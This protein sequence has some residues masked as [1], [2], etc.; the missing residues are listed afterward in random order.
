MFRTHRVAGAAMALA[1]AAAQA[2][3]ITGCAENRDHRKYRAVHRRR[4]D[5][6]VRSVEGVR[7]VE[8]D[9]VVR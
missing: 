3:A 9:L 2:P 1:L 7:S 5:Q 4:R 6:V 8:N